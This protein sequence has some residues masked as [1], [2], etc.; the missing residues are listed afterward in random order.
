MAGKKYHGEGKIGESHNICGKIASHVYITIN[1]FNLCQQSF[2]PFYTY[3][4][5]C[6]HRVNEPS[7]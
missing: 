6:W 2:L 3:F 5:K 1:L 4:F 7:I